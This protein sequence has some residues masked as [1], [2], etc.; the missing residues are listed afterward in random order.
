MKVQCDTGKLKKDVL[1]TYEHLVFISI[2]RMKYFKTENLWDID[3]HR[4]FR[5]HEISILLDKNVDPVRAK[6]S[7]IDPPEFARLYMINITTEWTVHFHIRPTNL[8]CDS[9]WK[10][11]NTTTINSG[12]GF[13]SM[14]LVF[15]EHELL[16]TPCEQESGMQGTIKRF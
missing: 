14:R 3:L 8:L 11:L 5:D 7:T 1:F 16:A 9:V 13:K 6:P 10:A 2:V 15:R 4:C 12:T